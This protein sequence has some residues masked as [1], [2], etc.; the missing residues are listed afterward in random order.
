MPKLCIGC[1]ETKSKTLFFKGKT[2]CKAC[3]NNAN[4]SESMV[5]IASIASTAVSTVADD[6]MGVLSKVDEMYNMVPKILEKLESISHEIQRI[7]RKLDRI[8]N[9]SNARFD[10]MCVRLNSL[11]ESSAKLIASN[12]LRSL[13]A[14]YIQDDDGRC[15]P[16]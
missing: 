14:K 11:E 12:A 10:A 5:D 13:S 7:D 2:V 16:M 3:D 4:M 8:Q 1:G 6:D 15:T 9:T